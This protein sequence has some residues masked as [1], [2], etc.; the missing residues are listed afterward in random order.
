M[1]RREFITVL[2]GAA[3]TWPLAAHA[4]KSAKIPR[5]AVF[6]FGTP[7][8]DNLLPFFRQGLR[9]LGYVEDRNIILE[10]RYAEGRP[11]RFPDLADALT[12]LK[13]D[14]ILAMGTDLAIPAKKATD[15]IPIV[16]F[17]SGDPIPAGLAIS[18]AHPGWNA[19]GVTAILDDLAPK[20]LQFLKQL[21]PR[22]ARIGF[23]WNPIHTDHEYAE[24][25]RAAV[26]LD[27]QLQSLEVRGTSDVPAALRAAMDAHI[28]ALYVVSARVTLVTQQ[29]I[30]DFAA[31]NKLP[32]A[33]GF[34]GWAEAGALLSYGPDTY[35][36]IRHAA[37]YIDK[38]LKGAKPGELPI[39]QP[40]KF[41]L[42]INLKTAKALGLTVPQTLLVAADKLIE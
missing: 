3:A 16:F 23:L 9:D 14:V 31:N 30:V 2:G 40:T 11:E 32:L 34:G 6:L 28:D 24:A 25:Q 19:T 21:A 12:L 39:E 13:P 33:T 8:A 26:A 41:E 42:V 4:Q 35:L 5:V 1:K 29:M 17:S 38:I 10:Y 20:R 7:Q 27:V 22:V 37:V 15:T 36:M 18:L